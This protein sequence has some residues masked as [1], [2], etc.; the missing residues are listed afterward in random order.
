MRRTPL[1][2][3]HSKLGGKLIDFGGWELPVQYSGIIQEHQAVRTMAGL[4]DV[5]H[6]GEITASG[7]RAEEF[8]Q[9]MVTNDISRMKNHQVMYSLMCYPDGGVVDDLLVY[10]FNSEDFLLVVNAGNA[11]KDFAWLELHTHQGVEVKNVSDQYAQLALQGPLA[12][13]VLQQLTEADLGSLGFFRF[14]PA[15]DIAGASVLLS[16]TGYTGEDGFEIYLS[17]DD[18]VRVWQRLLE[19]GQPFGVVPIGLGARD[20]LRFEAGLPLYGHEISADINP[21]EAGFHNFVKLGKAGFVGREA[22]IRHKEA[23]VSRKLIGFTM[24]DKGVPRSG[25]DVHADGQRIGF[26]TTG[27]YAPSLKQNVGLALVASDFDGDECDIVVRGRELRAKIVP[28]PLYAKKY[29][30]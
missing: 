14:W 4:F 24:L 28:L 23:G 27:S 20:T 15:V 25:Y 30:K 22:L 16:R 3:E 2:D 19:V 8:V 17:P 29:R 6:M 11:D 1:Y 18:A 7:P 13:A 5:S 9:A 21:L 10:K 26:V 12:Q